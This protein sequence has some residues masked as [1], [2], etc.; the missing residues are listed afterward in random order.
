MRRR[1]RQNGDMFPEDARLNSSGRNLHHVFSSSHSCLTHYGEI[2]QTDFG[3][4]WGAQSHLP[5]R[6]RNLSLWGDRRNHWMISCPNIQPVF[7][8]STHQHGDTEIENSLSNHKTCRSLIKITMSTAV[9]PLKEVSH[10]GQLKPT[11]KC[12]F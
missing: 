3:E 5:Q 7:G 4:F 1:R 11:S 8:A 10:P 2:L 6:P 9:S 12:T